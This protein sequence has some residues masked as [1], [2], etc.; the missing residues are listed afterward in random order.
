MI[1]KQDILDRAG[2]WQLRA[3]VVEKDYILGWLLAA[4]TEDG[5]TSAKWVFKG[6]TCLKKCY[7][8]TYRFSEDLD[9]TLLPD[10]AYSP[11][12]LSE[13]LQG[14]AKRAAELSGV[15]VPPDEIKVESLTD[16][17]KRPTF[18]AKLYYRGPLGRPSLCRVL[19]DLTKHEPVEDIPSRQPVFH[20][21]SDTLPS[22]VAVQTYSLNELLA[23]K[24]RALFERTRPRDLYDV[25]FILENRPEAVDLGLACRVFEKKCR[26]KGLDVPTTDQLISAIENAPELRSEWSNMLAHQL[27]QLPP[28]GSMI[29]HRRLQ[30]LLKWIEKAEPVPAM[31]LATAPAVSGDVV[32]PA[33]I[34]YWGG[35]SIIERLRFAGANHLCVRFV[36]GGRQREVEP[37]SLRR[38]RTGNLLFYGWELSSSQI[39]A[40]NVARMQGL[41][42]TQ[43]T[44][45][46]RYRVELSTSVPISVPATAARLRRQ[47][48]RPSVKRPRSYRSKVSRYGPTYVFQCPYCQKK[49]YHKKNDARLRKHKTKGGWDCPGRR[50][51]LVETRY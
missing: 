4:C 18:K 6:G 32:A 9:F 36:Y 21:Y 34:Q 51:Y 44:F 26:S 20:P 16:K 12:E 28:I 8:E 14:I 39:K 46:P 45:Y 10:A 30:G 49:F 40:F 43:R 27:P 48:S 1:G 19:F 11:D 7:F 23:E 50:G 17:Q 41:E 31:S 38:P 22:G 25:V 2:E 42:V 29:D 47:V 5:E 37:Y 24:T 13:I 15:E 3:D 33:G 35:D